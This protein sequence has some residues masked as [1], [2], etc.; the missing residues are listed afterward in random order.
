MDQ[1]QSKTEATRV[2]VV[3]MILDIVLGLGKIVGGIYTQSFALLT[4][5]IHS[6]TDAITDTF[7]LIVA[8]VAHNEP[9][10]EH[11]YGHGRFETLGTVAMGMVFFATAGVL[12]YD[13]YQRLQSSESLPIPA[14]GGLLFAAVSIAAK[15]W[16]YQ[17]TMRVARKLNSSL[18]KANAW[19]S[20][21]DAITSIAVFIGI[22]AAQ[23][24]LVWMDI[25]AAIFV[26]LFIAKI[27]FEL[28]LDS[29]RELVDTAVPPERQAQ[30]R[31][32]VESVEGVRGI[33]AL[34]SRLSGGKM[35]LELHLLVSPL[36]SVSEGHQLGRQVS[37]ALLGRFSDV[38][39]VIVHIDPENI[40]GKQADKRDALP[41]RLVV[42]ETIRERWGSLLD[43]ADIERVSLHY[44]EH[45][46]EIEL[47]VRFDSLPEGLTERLE[48][49]VAELDYLSG[50][51]V[52][53]KLYT[54][55]L[56]APLSS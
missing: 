39:D 49:A 56:G 30:L 21:S 8:R 52:Y 44:F 45:G 33:T 42:L 15:E 2:T 29:L 24:G 32:C 40:H 6:L 23:Q 3:G 12:L 7:V 47:L 27:G 10:A 34:R 31:Q 20:R 19:H 16:I 22:L 26:A 54:A 36:I 41:E 14:L 46:I 5:G 4:D 51:K 48:Q 38:G 18:L 25:V 28:C 11:P 9:D 1:N 53:N 17:Y 35:I 13:S 55:R 43:D 37:R 50:L